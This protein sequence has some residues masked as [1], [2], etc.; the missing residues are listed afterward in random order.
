[1]TLPRRVFIGTFMITRRTVQR[2]LLLRPD[3]K[4]NG[5]LL[6]VI[7]LG[8]KKFEVAIHGLT[9]MGNHYH[10]ICTPSRRNL[11]RFVHWINLFMA[12]L[13]NWRRGRRDAVWSSSD[14]TSVVHLADAPAVLEKLEYVALNAV[15]AGLVARP[16]Q[17]PGVRTLPSDVGRKLV[18]TRPD[19]FRSETDGT[20]EGDTGRDL[21]ENGARRKRRARR[22]PVLPPVVEVELTQPPQYADHSLADFRSL[23]SRGVEEGLEQIYTR[24]RAK[25]ARRFMGAWAVLHQDPESI[26]GDPDDQSPDFSLSPT[27]ATRDKW[28]RIELLQQRAEFHAAYRIAWGAFREGDR[29][30]RFPE[31][32]YGPCVLYG[33]RCFGD[34]PDRAGA[35]CRSRLA[36]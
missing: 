19:F 7:L 31:D 22:G 2:K 21:N 11:P 3:K 35:A 15:A 32:T 26:P 1:M 4:L 6:Y 16:E 27:I 13:V 8:S 20:S 25:G 30:V 33:A 10:L 5:A 28:R 9:I 14:K 36:A 18:A 17:Y 29:N 34:P 12:K 24:R 23:F